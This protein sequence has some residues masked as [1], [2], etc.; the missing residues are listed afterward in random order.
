MESIILNMS[1]AQLDEGLDS[2]LEGSKVVDLSALE[3]TNCYCSAEAAGA[4][5]EAVAPLPVRAVHWIDTGDYHYLSRF[6]LEKAAAQAEHFALVLFD[7][8]PDMQEPALGG[9]V[10]SCGGWARDAFTGIEGLTQVLALGINPDLE[11]EMLDLVFDGVLAATEDDFRHTADGL[12]QDVLEMISLLDSG[13]PV[14][15]SIDK[16]C[17]TRD[18][19][20]TDWDQGSMR[21]AQMEAAI[22]LI[23]SSHPVLGVD[24]CGGI[25]RA[26]GAKDEDFEVNL[27]TDKRLA[28]ILSNI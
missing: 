1:G 25:T 19:A 12:G 13:I 14:Y 24:V 15:F 6:W 26:K 23:A 2:A 28:A 18:F 8:H 5:R 17:L 22:S 21:L 20:R 7:R 3:G 27:A 4:I 11:I 10:L 9:D 16:D